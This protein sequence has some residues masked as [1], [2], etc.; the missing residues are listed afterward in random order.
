VGDA[1]IPYP[2]LL[3]RLTPQSPL[4]F[5][6]G[7]AAALA[8]VAV[9]M[10]LRWGLEPVVGDEISF[11][12]LFPALLVS[13]MLAGAPGAITTIVGGAIASLTI[14]AL[15]EATPQLIRDATPRLVV[16][17]LVGGLMT[18]MSLALR[19]TIV[20]LRRRQ[21]ELSEAKER[22]EVLTREL[23]HRGRN[24]LTIL[25]GLSLMTARSVDSVEA[26]RRELSR[27]I[28]AMSSA[29]SL[30]V[31]E[32]DK[33]RSLDGLVREILAGFG[34]QIRFSPA[35]EVF[36]PPKVC[37][38]LALALHELATNAVKY[39]ALSRP[40]GTVDL[41]WV[42]DSGG[43]LC[44]QW[45]EAGGLGPPERR[46]G[47]TGSQIIRQAF[48][49]VPGASPELTIG[50]EGVSFNVRIPM[51]TPSVPGFPVAAR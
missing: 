6:K 4:P 48:L 17:L 34:D 5:W 46:P 2:T 16:W 31:R 50:P 14:S 26:Y 39:G 37:V 49:G 21:I 33:P 15:G 36:V 51:A 12:T 1:T 35:K 8:T 27:R 44:L 7:Q 10:G 24:A 42:C 32:P 47:G 28:V 29:Y 45:R 3:A 18:A 20:A 43:T 9:A 41:K 22:Q 13:T 19:T 38:S 11:T 25:Q 30:L 40:G 23:E